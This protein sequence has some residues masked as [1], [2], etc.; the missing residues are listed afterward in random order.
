MIEFKYVADYQIDREDLYRLWVDNIV[1]SEDFQIGDICYIFGDD[2]YLLEINQ[3][4]LNHNTFTDIITFDY[5]VA[6]VVSGDIFISVDR[7]KEN[8]EIFDVRF[9]EE[10]RRVMAHGLLHLFGFG[11]KK[12]EEK[13]V[14]RRKEEEKMNM[15][16]VEQ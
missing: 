5:T 9:E 2:N 1:S 7:L 15:F 13:V 3:K 4:F 10:L 8:S 12:E 11:D 14:M 16:H 6:N